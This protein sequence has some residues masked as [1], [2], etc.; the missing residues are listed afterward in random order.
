M[1]YPVN[2]YHDLAFVIQKHMTADHCP[3]K[4]LIFFNSR[5]EAQA[6]AEFLHERLA[7]DLRNKVKWF[8]S[9]M[10]DE[11]CKEEMHALQVKVGCIHTLFDHVHLPEN[12]SKSYNNGNIQH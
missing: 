11:F 8:H 6:G 12:Q 10:T 2:S 1:Q 4:F 9:R 5:A 3:P 7:P